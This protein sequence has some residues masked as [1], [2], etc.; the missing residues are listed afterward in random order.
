M[1]CKTADY[2][3]PYYILHLMTHTVF[4]AILCRH[5]YMDNSTANLRNVP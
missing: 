3:F 1:D 5:H 2:S 4:I